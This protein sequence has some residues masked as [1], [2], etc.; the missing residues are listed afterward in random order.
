MERKLRFIEVEVIKEGL[1]V[2]EVTS[3]H[4]IFIIPRFYFQVSVFISS[5]KEPE[6]S[7]SIVKQSLL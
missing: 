6:L 4:F 5:E 2:K 3:F 7:N 1:E